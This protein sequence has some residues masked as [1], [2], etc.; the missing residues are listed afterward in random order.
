MHSSNADTLENNLTKFRSK[1]SNGFWEIAVFVR[2]RFSAPCI[3]NYSHHGIKTG[4]YFFPFELFNFD[5]TLKW[6]MYVDK[7]RYWRRLTGSYCWVCILM[8]PPGQTG[9]RRHNVFNTSVRS[10]VRA[11]LVKLVKTIFWKPMSRFAR[12]LAH[13]VNGQRHETVNFGSQEVKG[14]VTRGRR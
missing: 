5:D 3:H 11:S 8:P 7:R 1:I 12:K 9:K 10:S 14:Q 13:V 2:D 6:S 4:M